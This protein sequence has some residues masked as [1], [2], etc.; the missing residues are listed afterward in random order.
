M[1]QNISQFIFS[2]FQKVFEFMRPGLENYQ[3]FTRAL[4]KQIKVKEN[5]NIQY[6]FDVE[7]DRIIKNSLEEY[8][9]SGK[10]FSEESGFF[11]FGKNNYRVVYDP[12][13]NSSL[14]SKTFQEAAIGI[15]IFSYDYN[16][17]TSAIMDFQTGIVGIVEN[18]KTNFY[19]IQ[20]KEKLI[21]DY[22]KNEALENSWAVVTLE[23]R[24][25]R[26]DIQKLSEILKN[27]KRIIISSGHIYWLKLAMG[28]ID[29]YADPFGGEK[30]YEMFACSVAQNNG[31][32]VSDKIGKYFDPIE[33]LKIFENNQDYI[34][35]PVA[36][37][38]Q[39]LHN[40]ILKGIK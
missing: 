16:F 6:S 4:S 15:S 28:V 37:T 9:I 12:F 40:Q 33:N 8:G 26:K 7:L 39:T 18:G 2:T 35:Y 13:C 32:V 27:A 24:E 17:I 25:E 3:E 21:F 14:A 22:P 19:Q 1:D 38:N 10:I 5:D 20:S 30:L 29:A 36:A 23:N 34:Y 11:E 31:C